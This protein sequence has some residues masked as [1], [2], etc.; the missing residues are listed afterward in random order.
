[1]VEKDNEAK[2]VLIDLDLAILANGEATLQCR[3][4]I[5]GTLPFL[6]VDL[7]LDAPPLRHMYRYDLESFIWV[8]AWIL[9]R[10]NEDGVEINPSGL[11]GWYTGTR[12][13]MRYRKLGFFPWPFG[14]SAIRFPSLQESW[15][16]RLGRLF[17]VGYRMRENK[18]VTSAFDDE[19]LG[20][21]VTYDSFLE[22]LQ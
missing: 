16:K 14:N 4:A 19:T 13:E 17:H 12:N 3:P 6:S 2:G 21:C 9:I 15:L 18:S 5:G 22:I 10:F 1:M 20:G 8:L 11:S 7:L